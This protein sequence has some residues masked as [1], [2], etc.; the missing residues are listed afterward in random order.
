MI[1]TVTFNPS[2]DYV[3]QVEDLQLGKLNRT[4][5]EAL[6]PG[7]KGINVA[8]VLHN[9]GI[10]SVALGFICGFTGLYI[11]DTLTKLGVKNQFIDISD[12]FESSMSRIN[13]KVKSGL[14]T[15]INGQG[16]IITNRNQEK[17]LEQLSELTKED[18]LVLAGSIPS[19]MP[20]S[21]Y[22][23]IMKMLHT[24]EVPVVVDAEG[25]LLMNTLKYHPFLIKPNHVELSQ[26]FGVEVKSQDTMIDCAKKLQTQGARN[27]LVSMAGE[28]ALLLCDDGTIYY[29]EAPKGMVVNS[30]GAGDSMVA[31]FLAGY[32]QSQSY[33]E[34]L[35][36]G[37]FTGST[38][39]F[40]MD[41]PT[42]DQVNAL[43]A[44]NNIRLHTISEGRKE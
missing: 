2:L 44:K 38:A 36:M 28:G 22:E 9:L 18:M 43:M 40:S 30:V 6:Y 35:I 37:I 24:K 20:V 39:A 33:Q 27:V 10:D 4:K 42:L 19:S 16:P 8:R 11:Q 3:I 23:D 13:I 34:A 32:L 29:S 21:T 1:Y 26:I 7:G 15:E 14:E 5:Q 17:L 25:S 12:V 41:L 31:G